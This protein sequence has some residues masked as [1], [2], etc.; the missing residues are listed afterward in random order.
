LDDELYRRTI[1][2]LL[3]KCL[4]EEQAKVSM[5]EVHKGMC[6]THQSS[7]KMKWMLRRDGFFWP[8]MVAD[9]FKYFRGCEACQRFRDIQW[10]P[11]SMMNTV[12]KPWSFRGWGLDF[13]GEIHPSSSKGHRFVFVATNYFTKWTKAASLRNMTYKEVMSFLLEHIVHHFGIPQ[14]L[15][16]D[17]GAAFMSHQFKAFAYSL[18]I[19]VLLC[20]V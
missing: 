8:T 1:D 20:P 9:C 7:H 15:I 18:K 5:G 2:G 13:I 12:V 4:G 14:T 6:D 19:K 16:T 3:L 17:Q 11:A 10:A